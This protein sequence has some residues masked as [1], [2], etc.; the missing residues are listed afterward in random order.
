MDLKPRA[1]FPKPERT[2]L[3]GAVLPN[4][5][6]LKW[7]EGTHIRARD[8]RFHFDPDVLSADDHSPLG[9]L[10]FDR[11]IIARD[12]DHA[13]AIFAADSE[14]EFIPMFQRP[15]ED[16][17]KEDTMARPRATRSW[18]ISTFTFMLWLRRSAFSRPSG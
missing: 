4:I 5:F 1:V 18:P 10:T 14:L 12:V 11:D 9:R 2:S 17:D 7:A 3:A 6:I 13:N 16:L 15:E 8:G